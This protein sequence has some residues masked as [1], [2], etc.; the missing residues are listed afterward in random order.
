MRVEAWSG[1]SGRRYCENVHGESSVVR[2]EEAADVESNVAG[3][4]GKELVVTYWRRSLMWHGSR[5]SLTNR[6]RSSAEANPHHAGQA[7]S[8]LLATIAWYTTLMLLN[9]ETDKQAD[10]QT[11]RHT[12]DVR[13]QPT[14]VILQYPDSHRSHFSPVTWLLQSHTPVHYTHA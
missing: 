11:D 4:F 10:R 7:Y 1:Y 9:W 5:A 14:D 8:S 2:V 13:W 6:L 3:Y 12:D